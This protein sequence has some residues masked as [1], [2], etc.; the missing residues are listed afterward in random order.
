MQ[1]CFAMWHF[2]CT[3]IV[4]WIACHKPFN[5]FTP[6]RLPIVKMIPLCSFFAGFLILNNLSLALNGVGFYQLAK[7]MT[8]PT[9]VLLNFLIFRKTVTLAICVALFAVCFGVV[10][11][12]S[13]AKDSNILGV[14]IAVGAFTVTA[15]Y[16]IWIGKKLQDF[17]VSSSQLL[18]NQ[19]PLSIVLLAFV[20]PFF[21]TITDL[22]TVPTNVLMNLLLSGVVASLLNLS[23]FMIIGRMSALTFNVASNLKTIIILGLGWVS[24][25][26]VLTFQ[27]AIGIVLAVGGAAV[28]TQLSQR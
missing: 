7:I 16:Q 6:V 4:L 12:N 9:V 1:I 15:L 14:L 5:L 26:R 19:A 2:A 8:T 17:K 3:A 28:Y 25:G 11:T 23:Q 22:R 10:L 24:D 13:N 20:V 18:M 27:D 21:D